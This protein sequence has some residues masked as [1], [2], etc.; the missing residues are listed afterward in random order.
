MVVENGKW[1]MSYSTWLHMV[2]SDD[3]FGTYKI[4]VHYAVDGH[5]LCNAKL[6][7]V[8]DQFYVSGIKCEKCL[9]K[10]EKMNDSKK[11]GDLINE[12]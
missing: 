9:R 2:N 7:L 11:E 6:K 8:D 10:L 3:P 12:H 4:V 1:Y 5:A